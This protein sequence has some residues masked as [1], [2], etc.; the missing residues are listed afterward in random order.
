MDEIVQKIRELTARIPVGHQFEL[1]V[2]NGRVI[3]EFNGRIIVNES[4][5]S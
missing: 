4:L 1:V 3:A 5:P 2:R